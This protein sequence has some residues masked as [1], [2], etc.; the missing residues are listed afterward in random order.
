MI[1][2]NYQTLQLQELINLRSEKQN[3]YDF[4]T[5]KERLILLKQI[6]EINQEIENRYFEN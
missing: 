4:A 2:E 5:Y 6:K 3:E 1:T